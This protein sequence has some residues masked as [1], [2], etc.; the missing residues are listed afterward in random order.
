[1][2]IKRIAEFAD[3]SLEAEVLVDLVNSTTDTFNETITI[4]NDG[5]WGFYTRDIKLTVIKYANGL[6][7][8]IYEGPKLNSVITE[9]LKTAGLSDGHIV[10]L[11]VIQLPNELNDTVD[12]YIVR[13]EFDFELLKMYNPVFMH[14]GKEIKQFP[15]IISDNKEEYYGFHPLNGLTLSEVIEKAEAMKK[16]AQEVVEQIENEKALYEA[17]ATCYNQGSIK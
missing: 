7:R 11:L 2:Y 16:A 5:T 13:D 10:E 17:A 8:L 14:S 4:K 12:A 6:V 9:K 3:Y 15:C 1:M